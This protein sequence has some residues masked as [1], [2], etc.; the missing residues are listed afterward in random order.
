MKSNIIHY[1]IKVEDDN[2]VEAYDT[3]KMFKSVVLMQL[4]EGYYL[5]FLDKEMLK[6]NV[7][8][9]FSEILYE[10]KILLVRHKDIIEIIL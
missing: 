9:Q 4:K 2:I 1:L 8:N 3:R 10:N 7:E 6:V 5:G